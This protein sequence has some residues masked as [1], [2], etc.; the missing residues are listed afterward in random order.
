MSVLRDVLAPGLQIVFCGTA[1]GDASA[2]RQA[3]YAG[4]GNAFWRTLF[5][6]GLTP[7]LLQP[8]EYESITQYGLGLTDLAQ[9]ISGSDHVLRDEHFDRDGL[10]ARIERYVPRVLAFTSKR[11]AEEFVGHSVAYGLRDEKIGPTLI[12]VLPSPSGAARKYWSTQPWRELG[13]GYARRGE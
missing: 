11:A 13:R 12:H 2:R 10:R 4:P 5:E 3:Y 7:R 8:E 6:V 1:A 9:T